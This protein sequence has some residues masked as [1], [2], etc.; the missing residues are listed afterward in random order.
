MTSLSPATI[1]DDR[2]PGTRTFHFTFLSGPNCTG[3][4]WPVAIPDPPAPRNCGHASCVSP[5][6]PTVARNP[7][8]NQ[9]Q[10]ASSWHAPQKLREW[11]I[12]EAI[13]ARTGSVWSREEAAAPAGCNIHFDRVAP[14]AGVAA[15][16]GKRRRKA[17]QVAGARGR[18]RRRRQHRAARGR[19]RRRCGDSDKRRAGGR[20]ERGAAAAAL[21]RKRRQRRRAC[22]SSLR[23][24]SSD[25]WDALALSVSGRS[26]L[27]SDD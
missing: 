20:A 14:A 15:A 5:A 2:P 19:G 25:N 21:R 23:R 11:R 9:A 16:G 17:A 4:F 10:K 6:R 1:G 3:G 13:I 12:D 27:T 24:V 8:T 22:G 18:N 7:T 26:I